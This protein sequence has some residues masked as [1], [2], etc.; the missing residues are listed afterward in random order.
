MQ[1]LMESQRLWFAGRALFVHWELHRAR[2]RR[3]S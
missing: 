2:R 1:L 3:Q